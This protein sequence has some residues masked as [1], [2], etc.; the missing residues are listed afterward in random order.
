MWRWTYTRYSRV[1]DEKKKVLCVLISNYKTY[2]RYSWVADD[3]QKKG[4]RRIYISK[5]ENYTTYSEVA[6]EKKFLELSKGGN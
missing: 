1:A 6:D 4:L 5:F 3:K 2:T